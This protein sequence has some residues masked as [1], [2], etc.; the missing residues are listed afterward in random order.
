M[1]L[2]ITIPAMRCW[3]N[4]RLSDLLPVAVGLTLESL[5]K[6]TE[7]RQQ[8]CL[9][10]LL[11]VWKQAS[12]V[13]N[14]LMATIAKLWDCSWYLNRQRLMEWSS[15]LVPL[16][17]II[18]L[19]QPEP[20]DFW[21]QWCFSLAASALSGMRLQNERLDVLS[22]GAILYRLTKKPKKPEMVT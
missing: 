1:R 3:P 16:T 10:K 11:F 15:F 7:T 20:L 17:K 2:K 6:C 9:K 5:S 13:A 22:L 19:C 4:Y 14:A 12:P 8:R 18:Q 21:I